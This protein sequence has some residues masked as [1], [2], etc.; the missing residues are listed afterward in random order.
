M[1]KANAT[2]TIASTEDDTCERVNR[3]FHVATIL[4]F[5]SRDTACLNK[6]VS[7]M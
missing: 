3:L 2:Y 7:C 4:E 1:I 6:F 5:H